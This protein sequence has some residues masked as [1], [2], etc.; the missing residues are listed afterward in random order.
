MTAPIGKVFIS[1]S[2]IN[3]PFVD[4]LVADLASREIPAWYD[5]FDLRIGD[6]VPGGINAGL[7]EAKYF[8]IVLSQAA[9]TSRWVTEEL[10]AALMSQVAM[11]GT[12]ILPVLVE[13]CD[14]PPLLKHRRYADFRTNYD[15]GFRELLGVWGKDREASIVAGGKPLYPWPNARDKLSEAIYLHSTRFDKFFRMD[16]DLSETADKTINH[17]I[18]VLKL[19]W[20][21]EVPELGMKW[22][23]SYSLIFDG[24]AISLSRSL[25]E[26]GVSPGNVLMIGINGTYEDV[27]E[28]ELKNMWDGSKMY[29]MGSAL[30]HEAE[31]KEQIRK[32]GRLNRDRLREFANDCFS[33]V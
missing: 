15:Q 9:L 7:A 10:N 17:I 20:H 33:H 14:I 18:D 24:K 6:S 13:D 21:K 12:F 23:F 26:A 2:S 25:S 11:S 27:W 4:R 32:R 19:P 22:S 16:W 5:K 30:R 1:H 3:K 8:L 28:C 29:E 31:L